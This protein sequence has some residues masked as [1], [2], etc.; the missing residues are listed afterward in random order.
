MKTHLYRHFAADGQLLYVGISISA[1]E[2]FRAHQQSSH[3]VDDVVKIEI[4][5]F[6]SRQLALAAERLA[7]QSENPL[8]NRQRPAVSMPVIRKRESSVSR[9]VKMPALCHICRGEFLTLK[10][11]RFCSPR[12]RNAHYRERVSEAIRRSA[13]AVSSAN[14]IA[15]NCS[16]QEPIRSRTTAQDDSMHKSPLRSRGFVR[17]ERASNQNSCARVQSAGLGRSA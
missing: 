15:H 8:F 12:C 6:S 13:S 16:A 5:Y 14:Q 7:I 9:R 11:A 10:G 17:A 1:F 3:W 4:E 2:R